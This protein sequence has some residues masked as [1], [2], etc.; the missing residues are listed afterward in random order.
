MI[1]DSKRER[2]STEIAVEMDEITE[3]SLSSAVVRT[4]SSHKGVE[5]DEMPPI[6]ERIQPEALDSLFETMLS[7]SPVQDTVVTFS[8]DDCRVTISSTGLMQFD[9]STNGT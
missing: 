6:R 2:D 3:K 7:N 5:V 9:F 4:I 8:Y 1:L